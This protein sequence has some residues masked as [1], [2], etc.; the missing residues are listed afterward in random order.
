MAITPNQNGSPTALWS[1][2][3]SGLTTEEVKDRTIFVNSAMNGP[4]LR[5]STGNDPEFNQKKSPLLRACFFEQLHDFAKSLAFRF[6]KRGL[7]IR[8][9]NAHVR[10]AGKKNLDRLDIPLRGSKT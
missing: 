2:E 10:A 4:R 7:S 3:D 1:F 8:V 9:A 6:R 5:H